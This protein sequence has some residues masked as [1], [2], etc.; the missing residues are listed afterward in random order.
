MLKNSFKKRILAGCMSGIIMALPYRAECKKADVVNYIFDLAKDNAGN[1]GRL[2]KLKALEERV[3]KSNN[4]GDEE[5]G[6]I[7]DELVGIFLSGQRKTKNVNFY[8]QVR[9]CLNIINHDVSDDEYCSYTTKIDAEE[10]I[11]DASN[12]LTQILNGNYVDVGNSNDFW[13]LA[14]MS[15]AKNWPN[16]LMPL[17]VIT[18]V[19]LSV[20]QAKQL[21]TQA[22]LEN[23]AL[24][25]ISKAA[26]QNQTVRPPLSWKKMRD[27]I[28]LIKE[29]LSKNLVGQEEAIESIVDKLKGHCA[30]LELCEKLNQKP[31][32]SLVLN[33]YGPPGV[34]KSTAVNI[35][36][37]IL[38]S[39]LLN[40]GM[41]AAVEDNGKRAKTV[42]ARL[43]N[44]NVIDIRTVK[45]YLKTDLRKTL[46]SP[47]HTIIVFDE[48]EKM[49]QLDHRLSKDNYFDDNGYI[50]PGSL[51]EAMRDAFDYG[52]FA[53][54]DVSEKIFITISN[55]DIT[56]LERLEPSLKDRTEDNLVEFKK[57]DSIETYKELIVRSSSNLFKAYGND[58][59]NLRW[60]ESALEH[61]ATLFHK[62]EASGRKV[63]NFIDHVG[64]IVKS[65]KDQLLNSNNWTIDYNC[66]SNDVYVYGTDSVTEK[67]DAVVESNEPCEIAEL[68]G[69][70][71]N[72]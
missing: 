5:I 1:L 7:A 22:A 41:P 28:P 46:E 6:H 3:K 43:M 58:G 29:E 30:Y 50:L 59:I 57:F 42:L 18:T 35:I 64:S 8:S 56:S 40:L 61:Y 21:Q 31:R 27:S 52:L 55:D 54:Y 4:I 33:F 14:K 9:S 48:F 10:K 71:E 39:G 62:A 60:S 17:S 20:I 53:N 45:C 51:D 2:N 19:V 63:V 24:N 47:G 13:T 16:M 69:V 15:L 32:R 12:K 65:A 72:Q 70:R 37:R 38:G 67:D 11:S 26:K 36:S 23:N 25:T 49:R 68:V 44:D 34:G 66:E